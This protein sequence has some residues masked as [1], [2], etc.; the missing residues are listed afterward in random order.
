M[1]EEEIDKKTKTSL[2]YKNPRGFTLPS[3]MRF[4]FRG[5]PDKSYKLVPSVYRDHG[6]A[7]KED[8]MIK[9]YLLKNTQEAN[10]NIFHILSKMQH[11]GYPTRL[12]DW[13]GSIMAAAYFACSEFEEKDGMIWILEPYKLSLLNK[14]SAS[15]GGIALIDDF[16][17]QVRA[18]Q[19]LSFDF[20]ELINDYGDDLYRSKHLPIP[21]N[22]KNILNS[23]EFFSELNSLVT[24]PERNGKLRGPIAV[25]PGCINDRLTAQN[26]KFTVSGGKEYQ[27]NGNED[28]QNSNLFFSRPKFLAQEENPAP[29]SQYLSNLVIP[30]QHKA[31]I[32]VDLESILGM[33]IESFMLDLNSQ[34]KAA[35]TRL[36]SESRRP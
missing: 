28:D 12:L 5:H 20:S 23:A 16:D 15:L 18:L 14:I 29:E 11:Y 24:S 25:E 6:I 21:E 1:E 27:N 19:S 8:L 17:A 31:T 22:N 13:T 32:K 7:S 36:R 2:K 4:W 30:S 3:H 9:E 10:A 26:G 33:G 34:A 35:M